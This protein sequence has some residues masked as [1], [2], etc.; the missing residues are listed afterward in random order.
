[1]TR[2]MTS[3]WYCCGVQL[4]LPTRMEVKSP[5]VRVITYIFQLTAGIVYSGQIRTEPQSGWL[6]TTFRQYYRDGQGLARKNAPS[7]PDEPDVLDGGGVVADGMR[8]IRRVC[9][10]V[11]TC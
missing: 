2:T 9:R 4:S 11:L 3:G 8:R 10:V 1:M 6:Y 7:A 5:S